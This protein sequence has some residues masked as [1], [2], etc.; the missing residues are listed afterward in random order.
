MYY[1]PDH[2]RA[3]EFFSKKVI[4]QH[5]LRGGGIQNNIWRLMDFRIMWTMDQIRKYYGVPVVVNTY[6]WGGP[7]Q[8]R[9]FR[10][11][12]HDLLNVDLLMA[13]NII[14]SHFSSFTSQHCFGRAM[15]FVIPGIEA[16]EVRQNILTN[17][18]MDRYKYITAMEAD[19]N[20]VHIDTRPW[21]VDMDG[22]L[23]FRP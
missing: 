2:F 1:Q 15:D 17:R 12:F 13:T 16:E 21:N 19:V 22:L 11:N 9:G 18:R 3:E 8:Y 23:V 10:S 7:S 6:L 14:K 20:W 5:G 4:E